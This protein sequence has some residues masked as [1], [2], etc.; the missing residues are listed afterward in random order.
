MAGGLR[1]DEPD[2]RRGFGA[3]GVSASR[4]STSAA[5]RE[6]SRSAFLPRSLRVSE[7]I[8]PRGPCRRD[9]VRK[10]KAPGSLTAWQ[11]FL[12]N[13]SR[14]PADWSSGIRG[15]RSGGGLRDGGT[16]G[17]SRW[18]FSPRRNTGASCARRSASSSSS[19]DPAPSPRRQAGFDNTA[20][21]SRAIV[22]PAIA[23]RR[24]DELM[25]TPGTSRRSGQS[26]CKNWTPWSETRRCSTA[27]RS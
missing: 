19:D 17:P 8:R 25:E 7:G 21:S 4:C 10:C 3:W 12:E 22:G 20:M 15:N 9:A 5:G 24:F 23:A 13:R 26:Q 1:S 6:P 11:D 18:R 16:G 27:C 2:R 14:A